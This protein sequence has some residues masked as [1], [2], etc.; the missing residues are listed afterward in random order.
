MVD[1]DVAQAYAEGRVPTNISYITPEYLSESRDEPAIIAIAL[2]TA[3]VTI[4]LVLRCFSRICLVKSFGLDDGL[5]LLSYVCFV[6]FVALCIVLIDQGTIT[7]LLRYKAY[8]LMPYH[9]GQEDI[10]STSSTY[11]PTVKRTPQRPM[12]TWHT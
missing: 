12:T 11:L 6:A 7:D 9:Q 5:A 4:V 1:A 10:W 3:L 2:I 8:D